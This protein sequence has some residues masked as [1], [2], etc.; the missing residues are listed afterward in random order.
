VIDGIYDSYIIVKAV[1]HL[2][3]GRRVELRVVH[4]LIKLGTLMKRFAEVRRDE[5]N[6][7][8]EERTALNY[9]H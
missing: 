8:V 2:N 5:S 1:D 7:A 6:V 4:D 9:I 3:E